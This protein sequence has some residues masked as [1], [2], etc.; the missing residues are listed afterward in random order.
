MR[1]AAK[2]RKAEE[3]AQ[4][5]QP[6]DE[7]E[8]RQHKDNQSEEDRADGNQ[9]PTR[10]GKGKGRGRGGTKG[11]GRGRGRGLAKNA[12]NVQ[13]AGTSAPK[14]QNQLWRKNMKHLPKKRKQ[15]SLQSLEKSCQ[16]RSRKRHPSQRNPSRRNHRN[17]LARTRLRPGWAQ[18][19]G[20]MNGLNIWI[21]LDHEY[22]LV[23]H[24]ATSQSE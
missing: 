8:D 7:D 23:R 17:R 16:N 11:K 2:K 9:K 20:G 12:P 1:A 5:N 13:V 14:N 18:W 10:K 6:A 24:L 21:L 3:L 4:Y 22:I 19:A 15:K